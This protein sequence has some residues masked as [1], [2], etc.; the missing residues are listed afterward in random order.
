MVKV[1]DKSGVV[2]KGIAT[3]LLV[4]CVVTTKTG[5]EYEHLYCVKLKTQRRDLQK[6]FTAEVTKGHFL[7]H[8]I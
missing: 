3:A 2:D 4:N 7:H 6:D 5:S 8:L 1:T